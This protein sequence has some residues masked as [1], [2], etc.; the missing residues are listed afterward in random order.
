[1]ENIKQSQIVSYAHFTSLIELIELIDL[2]VAKDLW[3][4]RKK[5]D[6][7]T[8]PSPINITIKI[9]CTKYA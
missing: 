3:A 8:K 5:V 7:P 9:L 4:D 6:R 2:L 1:M